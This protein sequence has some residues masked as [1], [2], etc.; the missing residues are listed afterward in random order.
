MC[1]VLETPAH[2]Y[3]LFTGANGHCLEFTGDFDAAIG[4]VVA[5]RAGED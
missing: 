3:F 2:L 1:P 4:I 5:T